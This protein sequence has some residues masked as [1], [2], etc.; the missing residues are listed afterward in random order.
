MSRESNTN[1]FLKTNSTMYRESNINSCI[2]TNSTNQWER[3]PGIGRVWVVQWIQRPR[4]GTSTKGQAATFAMGTA[5][6][7]AQRIDFALRTRRTIVFQS[8][9]LCFPG[10]VRNSAIR[11]SALS[12]VLWK[13]MEESTTKVIEALLTN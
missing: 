2:E 11:R 4:G 3:N 7:A 10:Y 5:T 9:S 12:I 6:V 1:L 13:R 8:M